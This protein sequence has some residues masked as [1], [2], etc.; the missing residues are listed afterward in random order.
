M[1]II[2][3]D[4]SSLDGKLTKWKGNDIY[5]WSSREDFMHFQKVKAANNLIVMGSGTFKRVKDI[6]QAGLKPEKERLR[7]ILTSKPQRYSR[8]IVPGQMEFS[9]ETPQELVGRLEKEGFKQMLLVSGGKVAT[10]FFKEQLID[11]L[12]LTLEPKIFGSGEPLVREGCFD[13]NLKLLSMEKLNTQGTLLL[14]YQII[15]P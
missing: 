6:E 8:F 12:W 11:E 10:S 5:E 13:I 7:I 3:I 14:K 1:K 15:K 2:L 9:N 4:V